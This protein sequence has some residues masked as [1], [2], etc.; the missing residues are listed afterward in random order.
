MN[1]NEWE[2]H[3]QKNFGGYNVSIYIIKN[4]LKPEIAHIKDN[5][6]ELFEF[7]EGGVEQEPTLK[8]PLEVWNILEHQLIN[9]KVREKSEVEA[10]LSA[11]KYHLEDFRKLVFKKDK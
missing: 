3:I 6:L 1:N 7:L 5:Y 4:G 8:L 9:D 10:E 2:V 11:T